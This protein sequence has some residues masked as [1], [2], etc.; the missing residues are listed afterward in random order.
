VE[1]SDDEEL[2]GESGK[3]RAGDDDESEDEDEQ[4][5]AANE[6]EA[7]DEQQCDSNDGVEAKTRDSPS[8]SQTEDGIGELELPY[9]TETTFG[10]FTLSE[11]GTVSAHSRIH[12]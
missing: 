12:A 4:Q 8:P 6:D 2:A 5:A 9:V 1:K 11:L 7:G 10:T 3:S